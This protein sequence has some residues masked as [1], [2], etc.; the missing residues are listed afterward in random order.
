MCYL[1]IARLPLGGA[2][3]SVTG[4]LRDAFDQMYW[5][6]DG[7]VE[8]GLS[9]SKGSV[10][11]RTLQMFLLIATMLMCLHRESCAG[12]KVGDQVAVIERCTISDHERGSQGVTY[13]FNVGALV[14]VEKIQGSR[15]QVRSDSLGNGWIE[16]KS[17]ASLLD[18][19]RIFGD[20]ISR[21][22]NLSRAYYGRGQTRGAKGNAEGAIA[23]FSM[24]LRTEP[25]NSTFLLDRGKTHLRLRHL[26]LA[27]A[28]FTE[29]VKVTTG[30]A[31]AGAK[32]DR[33][34]AYY[35]RGLVR[36][37]KN[38]LTEA[39]ADFDQ[40][41]LLSPTWE[42]AHNRRG[43]AR[44]MQG[45]LE[46]SLTDFERAKELSP[47]FSAPR[48]YRAKT[49][50]DLGRFE[51]AIKEYEQAVALAP[52]TV[53]VIGTISHAVHLRL[54]ES[55]TSPV[56]EYWKLDPDFSIQNNLARLLVECPDRKLRNP[57]RARELVNVLRQKD[58]G[59]YFEFLKTEA[60]ILAAE[61]RHEEAR[62]TLQQAA[63]AAPPGQ[64]EE[65]LK[66]ADSIASTGRN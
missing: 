31:D 33:T 46:Q 58:H 4:K 51:E 61:N 10:M 44:R 25:G 1:R 24:A 56:E 66:S 40:A 13:I 2:F 36:Y 3:S 53:F 48:N 14:A 20:W 55:K 41:I 19:E 52:A 17:V 23:D 35:H 29:C 30:K 64:R 22:Q 8:G 39:I 37:E 65:I 9:P 49:L 27:Q 50:A 26:D 38:S 57:K 11:T 43:M 54:S 6:G 34:A 32:A 18:A 5:H 59:R 45:E 12:L 28:D 21:Q 63:N 15:I 7:L 47:T 16:A 62:Q 42:L 60:A